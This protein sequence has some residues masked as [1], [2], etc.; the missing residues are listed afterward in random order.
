MEHNIT[1]TDA[2]KKYISD[3]NIKD[4]SIFLFKSKGWACVEELSVSVG[5]PSNE[6][7]YIKYELDLVNVWIKLSVANHKNVEIGLSKL[8]FMKFLTVKSF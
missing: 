8:L 5:T 4:I 7:G 3:K 2:A 6:D 1:F